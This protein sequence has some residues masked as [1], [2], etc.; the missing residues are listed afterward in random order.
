MKACYFDPKPEQTVD[1]H[2]ETPE[3]VKAVLDQAAAI[4]SGRGRPTV[5]ITKDDGS[6]LAVSTDGERAFLVWV[7][8]L[9]GS[10]HSVG[11]AATGSMVFDYFGSWSEAPADHLVPADEIEAC[12]RG[13][14]TGTSPATRTVL[15]TPE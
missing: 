13:F 11:G 12:V 7:D 4:S 6:S 5:E 14:L 15:F 10:H 9:G 1:S 3:Q 8:S 2:V